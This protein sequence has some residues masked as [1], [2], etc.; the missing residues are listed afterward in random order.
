MKFTF[1]Y[2]ENLEEKIFNCQHFNSTCPNEGLFR[3]CLSKRNSWTTVIL[4]VL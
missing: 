1:L 3:N 4:Y 2:F